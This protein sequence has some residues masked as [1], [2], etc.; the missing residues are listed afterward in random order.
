MSARSWVRT[1]SARSALRSLTSRRP[2]GPTTIAR[3]S[4]PSSPA[5]S[6]GTAKVACPA[7][8]AKTI[9]AVTIRPSPAAMRAYA[10]QPP[11]PKTA[12]NGSIRP[13][14]S[15][16]RSRW[17][18]SAWRHSSAMPATP[19]T[20]GQK[21]APWP[22]IALERRAR[23]RRSSAPSAIA[24][25]GVAQ[26][27]AT[28]AGACRSAVALSRP[29]ALDLEALVGGQEHPQAGVEHQPEAAEEGGRDEEAAHPQHRHAE[30]GG[31]AGRDAAG[32]RAPRG[33]GRPGGTDRL[34][35]AVCLASS[36]LHRR[37]HAACATMRTDP[38]PT[39]S[40]TPGRRG[41]RPRIRAVPDGGG[42]RRATQSGAMDNASPTT[43]STSTRHRRP[44][45]RSPTTGPRVSR[46]EMKDLGRLRRSVTDRHIAGV[47]GGIARHLDIDPI[48]VRVALVVAVFFGGAGLLALHRRLAPR[49]R[50]GHRRRAA[51]PRPAQP[52]ARPRRGRRPRRSSC[53]VGDWAG[54]FWFPWPLAIVAAHR[55]VFLHRKERGSSRRTGYGYAAADARRPSAVRRPTR[56]DVVRPPTY[57]PTDEPGHWAHVRPRAAP[58]AQPAQAR[59]DPVLLHARADRAGRG[60]PRCRRPRRR[61]RR[62]QRLPRPG[63]R[64]HRA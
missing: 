62:R 35:G 39:L 60:G 12:R 55:G 53:A 6:T 50:G 10:A 34:R 36:C 4:R 63:P 42:A 22:K 21:S 8:T 43:D 47:A 51:R 41:E 17:A 54:A 29:G 20:T 23:R 28:A 26:P 18:S 38:E 5:T 13:V 57:G 25:P 14:E 7:A 52:L 19:R 40:P 46:D 61:R 27:G 33:R 3:P 56:R 59:T 30:V 32:D 48:I 45:V 49:A 11:L 37:R 44:A 24:G 15:V 9:M 1:R 31:Q 58:P 16:H 2:H 64:R